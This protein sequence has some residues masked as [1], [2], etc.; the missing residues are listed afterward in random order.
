MYCCCGENPHWI[1]IT[2]DGQ[3][4]GKLT[5]KP[6]TYKCSKEIREDPRKKESYQRCD[7][8]FCTEVKVDKQQNPCWLGIVSWG[9]MKVRYRLEV[10]N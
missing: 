8:L 6:V 2:T 1:H 9:F 10:N 7:H 4:D 3:Q 5:E